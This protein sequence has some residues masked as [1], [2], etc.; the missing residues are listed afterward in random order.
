MDPPHPINP[1]P[2]VARVT[3]FAPDVG[4]Q[5]SPGFGRRRGRGSEAGEWLTEGDLFLAML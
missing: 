2:F 1:G 3:F 4:G 5:R